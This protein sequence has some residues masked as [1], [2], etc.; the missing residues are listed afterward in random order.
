MGRRRLPRRRHPV[1]QRATWGHVPDMPSVLVAIH[2]K[3]TRG[4]WKGSI[5]TSRYEATASRKGAASC[6]VPPYPSPPDPSW[7]RVIG[8][9]VASP[10]TYTVAPLLRT[11]RRATEGKRI[12][13]LHPWR[14]AVALA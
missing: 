13:G 8:H 9:P 11:L 7:V 10:P 14:V 12:L 5:W 2:P 3:R 6:W 4:E 1:R